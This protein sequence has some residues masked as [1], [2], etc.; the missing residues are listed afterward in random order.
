MFVGPDFEFLN[1]EGTIPQCAI[2]RV[3]E[4]RRAPGGQPKAADSAATEAPSDTAQ[5]TAA[6][7]DDEGAGGGDDEA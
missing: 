6:E 7:S 3:C 1:P 4:Q 2:L 5:P